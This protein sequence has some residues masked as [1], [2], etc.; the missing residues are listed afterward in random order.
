MTSDSNR[1]EFILVAAGSGSRIGGVPK[2]FR[3]LGDRPMWAWSAGVAEELCRLGMIEGLVVVVPD[4]SEDA[5]RG[6]KIGCPVTYA[7]GGATRTE[8][9][10]K[11]LAAAGSDFVLIH[12]A[13]RP[14]L[15]VDICRELMRAVTRERAAVPV[16]G[17]ADSIERV[18]GGVV[19]TAPRDEIKRVQTPQAFHRESIVRVLEEAPGGGT[20][21]ASSW[22]ESG[23]ELVHVDGSE[24]NFK[25]TT[26]F[27]W[28]MAASLLSGQREIRVG[29][30]YDRHELVPGRGLVLGGV[31]IPC[32]L[33]LL[34]HSD[35][36]IICHSVSDALLGAA[37]EG[38]IGTMFPASDEAYRGADSMTLLREVL[39]LISEKKWRVAWL[40]IILIAQIPRLGTEMPKIADN[41][42]KVFTNS[43]SEVKL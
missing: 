7:A 36:D 24:R 23:G 28:I 26:D 40:D 3:T 16:I 21:E 29:I 10:R 32:C 5:F 4:G 14:F 20:D 2:Q 27:D 11:G 17:S 6:W 42:R 13:A 22:L 35:A 15:D 37:G 19:G 25:V 31:G 9:V 34:G 38:D 33:G 39:R 30:G 8:S 18:R 43:S 12:D 1:W 41:L